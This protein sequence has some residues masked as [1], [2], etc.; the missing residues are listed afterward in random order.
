MKRLLTSTVLSLALSLG[1]LAQGKGAYIAPVICP[2]PQFSEIS[3]TDYV[4][5]KEV[6]LSCPDDDAPMWAQKHLREWYGE[7]AP[8]VVP[9]LGRKAGGAEG[10]Y[11]LEIGRKEVKI[12]AG[13]L[14]GVRYALYSLRQLAIPSRGTAKVSGW[15]VPIAT[16]KDRPGLAFRG[17]HI[18]WFHE[19]EPWEV[20]RL[21]RRAAY[22]KLN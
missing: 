11:E 16:V 1:I 13:T 7:Y 5:L 19:T 10:E 2:E 17:I 15:I 4:P 9:V 21:V 22:H 18:C 14:Q 6:T 20:E 12:K 8:R 3:P